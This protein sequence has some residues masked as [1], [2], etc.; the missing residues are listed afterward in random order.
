[1]LGLTPAQY[2]AACRSKTFQQQLRQEPNVTRAVYA[3]GYGSGSRA[4]EKSSERLGMTPRQFQR[5]GEGVAISWAALT[6]RLGK[7][8]VGATDRGLCF[9][10]F[11]DDRRELTNDLRSRFPH[12]HI[13]QM[14]EAGNEQ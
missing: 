1:Q 7:I 5:G 2:H 3:A 8:V 9:L 13:S 14:L 4:Y 6:T 10:A 12:A 11:G